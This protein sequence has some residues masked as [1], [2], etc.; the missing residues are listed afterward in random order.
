MK[1]GWLAEPRE[2]ANSGKALQALDLPVVFRETPS[3]PPA[4]IHYN[5]SPDLNSQPTLKSPHC[6]PWSVTAATPQGLQV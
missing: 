2:L 1:S 4:P 6:D 5:K 3:P